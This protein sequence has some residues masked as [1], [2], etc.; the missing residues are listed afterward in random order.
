MEREQTG[1]SGLLL[2]LSGCYLVLSA[3][4]EYEGEWNGSNGTV[5]RVKG[6]ASMRVTAKRAKGEYYVHVRS[7]EVVA[8]QRTTRHHWPIFVF[9]EYFH[10]WIFSLPRTNTRGNAACEYVDPRVVI[11]LYTLKHE[12]HHACEYVDPRVVNFST[13]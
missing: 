6:M 8:S 4:S 13:R 7:I 2:V 5:T 9:T 1:L 12:K 3:C 11:F 10:A